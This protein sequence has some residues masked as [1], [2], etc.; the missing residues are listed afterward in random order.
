MMT[1]LGPKAQPQL[2]EYLGALELELDDALYQRLDDVSA[3]EPGSPHED[4]AGAL[5]H[6]FDGDRT[7]LDVPPV[8]VV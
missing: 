7:T 2:A 8:P 3:I 5:A 6:G 1:I 4:V